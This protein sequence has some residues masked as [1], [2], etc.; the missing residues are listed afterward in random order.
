MD[1]VVLYGMFDSMIY[2]LIMHKAVQWSI[3]RGVLLMDMLL[4]KLNLLLILGYSSIYLSCVMYV[5]TNVPFDRSVT[6]LAF[7][8]CS[9]EMKI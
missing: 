8:G 9:V 3:Q 4:C 1:Y 6:V 7:L 5:L 2:M